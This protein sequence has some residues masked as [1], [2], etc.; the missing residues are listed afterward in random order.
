MHQ[1]YPLTW[2]MLSADSFDCGD[3]CVQS[4]ASTMVADPDA[5]NAVDVMVGGPEEPAASPG[6]SLEAEESAEEEGSVE[7]GPPAAA[8]AAAPP[9]GL[10]LLPMGKVGDMIRQRAGPA[11]M[12]G[13]SG[14]A[15]I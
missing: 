11:G 7:A 14:P 1:G 6:S 3:D 4:D 12:S 9:Q 2:R 15:P 13:D 10:L 8:A 5:P